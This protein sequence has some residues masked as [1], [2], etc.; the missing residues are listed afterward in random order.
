MDTYTCANVGVIRVQSQLGKQLPDIDQIISYIETARP[1]HVIPLVEI[2]PGIVKDLNTMIFPVCYIYFAFAI[3]AYAV[4]KVE[5]ARITA[6]LAPGAEKIP[7]CG[8][9]VNASVTVS[10][11]DIEIPPLRGYGNFSGSIEWGTTLSDSPVISSTNLTQQFTIRGEAPNPM[12][13]VIDTVNNTVLINSN[14][15]WSGEQ[16]L[17]PA[18]KKG[19]ILPENHDGVGATTKDVNVILPVD[20]NIN[21]L[22]HLH[23][24]RKLRPIQEFFV[25]VVIDTQYGHSNYIPR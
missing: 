2:I 9:F 16:A 7:V 1:V 11:G 22:A 18:A 4:G 3:G 15:V 13:I 5:L 8:E 24:I 23:T 10:V 14:A 20:S 12:A 6:I 17:S 19:S 25:A 21:H